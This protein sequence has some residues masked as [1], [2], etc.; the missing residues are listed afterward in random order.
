MIKFT[1]LAAL[2]SMLILGVACSEPEEYNPTIDSPTT[3]NGD[4]DYNT[5]KEKV[6]IVGSWQNEMWV[7]GQLYKRTTLTFSEDNTGSMVYYYPNLETRTVAINH[8]EYDMD[9]CVLKVNYSLGN[10]GK[11]AEQSYTAF[12]IDNTVLH[13]SLGDE[14]VVPYTRVE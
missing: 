9:T 8:Y 14:Q 13:T 12:I 2:I 5:D 6:S 3:D 4:N 1:K 11:T 10:D 7:N